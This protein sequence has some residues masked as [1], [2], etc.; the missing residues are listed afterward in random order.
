MTRNR[1]ALTLSFSKTLCFIKEN[2]IVLWIKYF[3]LTELIFIGLVLL[4]FVPAWTN[5]G[6]F[7]CDLWR[8]HVCKFKHFGKCF[9]F[10]LNCVE[11]VLGQMLLEVGLFSASLFEIREKCYVCVKWSTISLKSVHQRWMGMNVPFTTRE[12]EP[13]LHMCYWQTR[14]TTGSRPRQEMD[15]SEG[16]KWV[17]MSVTH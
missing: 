2:K 5:K 15:F 7:T 12:K 16:I 1:W 9:S 11:L 10:R 4:L 14:A 3:F 8:H 13:E 6:L 17:Q